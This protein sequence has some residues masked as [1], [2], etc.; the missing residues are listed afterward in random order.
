MCWELR[1][2]TSNYDS[3]FRVKDQC[4]LAQVQFYKSVVRADPIIN[5]NRAIHSKLGLGVRVEQRYEVGIGSATTE[6]GEL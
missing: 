1:V 4:L 6:V 3:C 5:S 2:S